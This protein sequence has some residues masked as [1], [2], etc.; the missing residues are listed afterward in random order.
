[1]SFSSEGYS[2]ANRWKWNETIGPLQDRPG[3]QG[4]CLFFFFLAGFGLAFVE[5]TC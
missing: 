2:E 5:I 3:R 1:M 4:L